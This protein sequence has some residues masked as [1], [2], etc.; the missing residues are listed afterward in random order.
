[1]ACG[2]GHRQNRLNAAD[3]PL[4]A[5]Q[6]GHSAGAKGGPSSNNHPH[7]PLQ[8]LSQ[9]AVDGTRTDASHDRPCMVHGVMM[10]TCAACRPHTHRRP[11][12]FLPGFT[13]GCHSPPTKILLHHVGACSVPHSI[14]QLPARTHPAAEPSPGFGDA[15]T[16]SPYLTFLEQPYQLGELLPRLGSELRQQVDLS[17]AAEPGGG[18]AAG[19]LWT[20]PSL[21]PAPPPNPFATHS[22]TEVGRRLPVMHIHATGL[23][24]RTCQRDI[25]RRGLMHDAAPAA[26][27][28]EQ[29]PAICH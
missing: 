13:A 1:M 21:R 9:A 3:K 11:L 19:E 25:R 7:H 4:R 5:L 23:S 26:P 17:A 14:S 28:A 15:P 27:P 8:P 2:A 22:Q 12:D 20:E 6:P 29:S 16:E 10:S 24:L 18:G